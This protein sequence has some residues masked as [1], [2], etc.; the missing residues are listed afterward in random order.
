MKKQTDLLSSFFND[1][2]SLF[3]GVRERKDCT[4]ITLWVPTEYKQKFAE[5]QRKTHRKFGK[6]VQELL[7]KSIDCVE[8]ESMPDQAS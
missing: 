7:I 4:G 2:D 5:L 8:S 1:T 6:K 3:A